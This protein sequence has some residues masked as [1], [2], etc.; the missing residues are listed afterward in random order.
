MSTDQACASRPR[1]ASPLVPNSKLA[2]DSC[3]FHR[4]FPWTICA[5]PHKLF[6]AACLAS[7]LMNI[8]TVILDV[9][10]LVTCFV[11]VAALIRAFSVKYGT[12][13]QAQA[14]AESLL[15]K[16]NHDL[17]SRRRV[18]AGT[19]SNAMSASCPHLSSLRTTRIRFPSA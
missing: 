8:T 11:V 15:S 6:V 5:I 18:R 12:A 16:A 19:S 13:E 14:Q 3:Q 2:S 1:P 10:L 9:F 7:A 4:E 17:Q